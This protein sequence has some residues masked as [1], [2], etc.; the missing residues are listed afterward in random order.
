MITYKEW[1]R[2]YDYDPEKEES[3]EDY[4]RYVDRL[5]FL[6]KASKEMEKE[7]VASPK[8]DDRISRSSRTHH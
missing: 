3:K 8:K 2:H 5:T 1:C 7:D 6:T 4:K